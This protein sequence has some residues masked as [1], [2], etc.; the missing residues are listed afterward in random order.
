MLAIKLLKGISKLE[1]HKLSHI[2]NI[3]ECHILKYKKLKVL[4][5]FFFSKN[6]WFFVCFFPIYFNY[7]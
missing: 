6:N 7:L 3:P 5:N 4:C 2:E 1:C